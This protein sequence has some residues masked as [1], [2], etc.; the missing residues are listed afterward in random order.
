M[1]DDRGTTAR[2]YA[3]LWVS[4]LGFVL[5][6]CSGDS[7]PGGA[8]GGAAEPAGGAATSSSGGAPVV[9]SG[10]ASA[11]SG[12]APVG[13]PSDGCLAPA[14]LQ[15]GRHSLDVDGTARE[16]ILQLPTDYDPGRGPYPLIFAWHGGRYSADWVAEGGEPQSGPYFGIQSQ[17]GS[18][19]I[20]VAPQALP[21]WT[22]QDLGFLDAM[23][24]TLE[25]AL[26][27]DRRRLFSTGFSMGGIMTLDIG[28]QRADVFR[29]I[30]PMS[31]S[32][33]GGC[34]GGSPVAY[35]SSHGNQD[36]TIPP[37]EGE[38]ARDEFARNN[39]CTLETPV[40]GALGFEYQGCAE[41]YPVIWYPFDGIHEP[42]PDEGERIWAFFSQF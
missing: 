34:P 32:L 42:P 38:A 21:S 4:G 6:A 10:G 30:A 29:A 18:D 22:E 41:G 33:S 9:G 39:G 40:A 11:S 8:E 15:S 19:V 36:T 24:A 1:T 26:C 16:F 37:S 27:V 31:G 12:G 2:C 17:A 20:L 7:S 23:V 28:C 3:A 5:A 14:T 35:F 13:D 25:G